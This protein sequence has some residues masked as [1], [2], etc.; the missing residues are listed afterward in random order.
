MGSTAVPLQTG[1]WQHVKIAVA[2]SAAPADAGDAGPAGSVSVQLFLD[3]SPEA[4]VD[5]TFPAPFTSAPFARI[6]AGL[7]DTWTSNVD[8]WSIYYDNITLALQ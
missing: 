1:A 8:N 6:S 3:R 2:F 7:V 5:T 4:V